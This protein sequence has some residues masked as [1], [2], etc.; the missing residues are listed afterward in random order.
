MSRFRTI[1]MYF[2]LVVVTLAMLFG[3]SRM[4]KRLDAQVAEHNLRFTGQI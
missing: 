3:I 1:V 4:E 2:V